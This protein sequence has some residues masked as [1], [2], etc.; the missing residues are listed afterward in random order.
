[1][2]DRGQTEGIRIAAD[3]VCD[4]IHDPAVQKASAARQGQTEAMHVE[5]FVVDL[6]RSK[7]GPGGESSET[8]GPAPP[9]SAVVPSQGRAQ[10]AQPSGAAS[11]DVL[12]L[13]T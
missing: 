5:E 6:G 10:K 2:G 4:A 8:V 11:G 7:N 1:M 9:P 13:K 3:F 12:P